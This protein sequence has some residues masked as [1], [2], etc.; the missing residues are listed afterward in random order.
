MKR[1][2]C[3]LLAVLL[4]LAAALGGC[5]SKSALQDG[6]YTAE[7]SGYEHG[8]KEFVTVTVKGG[9]I[10]AAEYNA[11]NESGFIKSWDNAYMQVMLSAQGTYPNEYTRNYAAQLVER[12]TGEGLATLAGASTSATTFS[13]LCNAVVQQARLGDSRTTVV[14]SPAE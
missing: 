9:K 6:Y 12:Q 14:Q 13:M 10:V 8:W 11:R 5:A 3:A 4:V 2:L 1:R 7:M